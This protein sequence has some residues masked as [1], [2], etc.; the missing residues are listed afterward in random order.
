MSSFQKACSSATGPTAM[1]GPAALSSSCP[2]GASRRARYAA[3]APGALGDRRLSPASARRGSQRDPAH[4]AAARSGWARPTASSAGSLERGRGWSDARPGVVPI[5]R[6]CRRLR[7]RAR[8]AH[9]RWPTADARYAACDAATATPA[10]RQRRGRDRL[11]RGQAL[12]REGWTKGGLGMASL[13]LGGGGVVARDRGRQR[14]RRSRSI[15]DG[16]VLAGIWRDGG[17]V[18]CSDVLREQGQRGRPAGRRRRS[19]ACSPMRG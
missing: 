10:A 1:P 2:T 6:G 16:S 14:C 7:P 12:A 4:R 3:A 11:H 18:R 9:R 13:E 5:V 15:E 17:Y 19:S 8:R